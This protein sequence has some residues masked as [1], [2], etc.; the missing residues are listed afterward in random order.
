MPLIKLMY[1]E[2]KIVLINITTLG[3]SFS[4]IEMSLKIL[5]LLVTI[6][7]TI[8]KWVTIKKKINESN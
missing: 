6:G 3:I 1:N 8:H 7:Y 4:N 2:M 5:L